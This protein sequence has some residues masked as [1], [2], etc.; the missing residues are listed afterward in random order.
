MARS[1]I[2]PSLFAKFVGPEEATDKFIHSCE[3]LDIFKVVLER[4][5]GTT[6][7]VLQ[8]TRGRVWGSRSS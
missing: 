7:R 8:I 3:C 1:A 4:S 5:V 6:L 2:W